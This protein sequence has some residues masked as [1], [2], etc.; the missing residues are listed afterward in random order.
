MASLVYAMEFEN[1]NTPAL[2][3]DSTLISKS[4]ILYI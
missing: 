4:L 2:L 3:I 1:K